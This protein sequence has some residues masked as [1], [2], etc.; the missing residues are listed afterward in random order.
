MRISTIDDLGR[1]LML[2]TRFAVHDVHSKHRVL[3]RSALLL[4]SRIQAQGPMTTAELAEA[5][6]FDVSTVHRQVSAA[7]KE[8]LLEHILDPAGGAA[9]KVALTELGRERLNAELQG[10]QAGL[11]RILEEWSDDDLDALTTLM[12]RYNQTVEADHERP[13]PREGDC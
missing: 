11:A 7:I 8:D 12:R 6:G 3:S 2:L 13:W 1:E 10:R 5:F 4:L 9:R